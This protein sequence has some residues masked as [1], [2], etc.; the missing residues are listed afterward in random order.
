MFFGEYKPYSITVVANSDGPNDKVFNTVEFRADS[1]DGD[2][3]VYNK[4]FDTLDVYNEYQHG[5]VTLTNIIGK[6]SSLKRKF[7][8]WRA[9]IPRANTP[10]NGI[11]SNNR[12]RIRNTWAYIKLSTETPNTYRTVFHDM[13][14]HYFI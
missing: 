9:N 13:N 12:D 5:K 3:L 6:P 14:I 10:I 1:Y 7:R 11:T 2:D 8:V 4:T